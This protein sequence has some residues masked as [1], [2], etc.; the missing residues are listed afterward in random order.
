MRLTTIRAAFEEALIDT[1]FATFDGNRHITSIEDVVPAVA[2]SFESVVIEQNGLGPAD[3]WMSCTASTVLMIKDDLAPLEQ[4]VHDIVDAVT[5]YWRSVYPS[6]TI[7]L[8]N[9][10]FLTEV[11]PDIQ[12][13]QVNWTIESVFG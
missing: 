3:R 9:I 11:S 2:V 1:K 6:V 4:H 12:A 7:L 10:D 13:A 8:T 5:T